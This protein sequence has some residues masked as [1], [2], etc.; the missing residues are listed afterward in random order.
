M[1]TAA[2]PAPHVPVLYRGTLPGP[3]GA[4]ANQLN[5]ETIE[6]HR[7]RAIDLYQFL[8]N[9][10]KEFMQLNMENT[11]RTC[12]IGLP[13]SSTVRVLH[14]TGVGASGLGAMSDIDN[15]L[16]FL[17]GDGGPDIG[18]PLPL[19][20]PKSIATA[21]QVISMTTT[22]FHANLT[23]QGRTYTWPLVRR[24]NAEG[25]NGVEVMK[26]APIPSYLVLDGITRDLDAAEV[27]E[28]IESLDNTDGEM[29][30][31]LKNFLLSV[32]T[33][34]NVNDECPRISQELLLAPVS[35]DARRWAS[36]KFKAA[37][38]ALLPVAP[39]PP[40]ATPDIA[41]ILAQL[42]PGMLPQRPH[43]AEEK[44]DDE[45]E[46]SIMNMSNQ[47]FTTTLVMCG[48]RPDALPAVLPEW[49]RL[50]SE[51]GMTDSFRYTI[52]NKH[53]MENFRY[54][55]AEVP[56]TYSVLKMVC[57]R[58]WTGKEGNVNRPSFVNS[59]E[60]L[61]PFLLL[62][63]TEDEVATMNDENDALVEASHV[64]VAQLKS[65]K[66]RTKATVPNTPEKFMLL[67]KK[68]AN[69]LFALF[70]ANC[71]LFQCLERVISAL[72]SYSHSA[73]E[74]MPLS[75][76]AS[77]LWVILKQS[78]RFAIG[79]MGILQEYEEMHRS[80]SAKLASFSHAE[81]PSQLYEDIIIP[82]KR[83]ADLPPPQY[84]D[85]N[86]RQR[87]PPPHKPY[88][89]HNNNTWH[90]KLREVLSPHLKTANF[91]TFT[92]IMKYCNA[93]P[94]DLYPR[95]SSKCGPNAFFGRCQKGLNCS[96]DHS[97]PADNDIEKILDMTKKFRLNP[98]GIQ[99]G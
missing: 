17:S 22:Q 39:P 64:T 27:L 92:A 91:P 77:I 45:G 48:A 54:E 3:I 41:A 24:V 30:T 58:N 94:E 19:T 97:L 57:K 16:L 74:K 86:K 79:E 82:E 29:F 95:Y 70:S 15:K 72:R 21:S 37:Y 99:R 33:S 43:H 80:L 6:T 5:T 11:A 53:I 73:R 28:R 8:V 89:G 1:A 44:K 81:T 69:L 88:N 68:Y 9:D 40:A 25:N 50:C 34:H 96:K 59:T 87:I 38:P 51:K 42:L 14:T 75:T 61:S 12:L 20:L 76:K 32:L 18:S 71:T 47:E 63:L 36:Q 85:Y 10:D 83:K 55:D 78:R 66:T 7:Q 84:N 35:A 62:D 56:L 31:H 13:S 4:V 49:F 23:A 98:T 52:I 93:N 26:L 65:V 46:T 90:P 60:G 2:P 67:L